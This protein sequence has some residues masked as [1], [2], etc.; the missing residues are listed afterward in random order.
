MDEWEILQGTTGGKLDATSESQD[1]E[2][3]KRQAILQE[4]VVGIVQSNE[5]V[6][7]GEFG[8]AKVYFHGGIWNDDRSYW[9]IFSDDTEVGYWK[10]A[11]TE[12]T[13]TGKGLTVTFT[14]NVFIRKL[15]L[16]KQGNRFSQICLAID[17]N[18]QKCSDETHSGKFIEWHLNHVVKSVKWTVPKND[19]LSVR[20]FKIFYRSVPL[21]ESSGRDEIKSQLIKPRYDKGV[22]KFA[23]N[24]KEYFKLSNDDKIQTLADANSMCNAFGGTVVSPRTISDLDFLGNIFL[25]YWQQPYS[26]ENPDSGAD[27][28][29]WVNL[30]RTEESPNILLKKVKEIST[31]PESH[32]WTYL[33][34]NYC[35]QY[36]NEKTD[37]NNHKCIKCDAPPCENHDYDAVF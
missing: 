17:D 27:T 16:E 19:Y 20:D 21:T 36:S 28:Q 22:L 7:H 30:Q 35:C 14:E 6:W 23:N 37:P 2:Y 13:N 25:R 8:I 10:T 34:G 31:C 26:D 9:E 33:A 24:G 29:F 15:Q 4:D 5:R 3:L 12:T 1:L 11:E 32:P 18:N